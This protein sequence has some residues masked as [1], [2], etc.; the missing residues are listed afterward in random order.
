[1]LLLGFLAFT[2]GLESIWLKQSDYRSIWLK[3][4]KGN[5]LL[6][7]KSVQVA[8]YEGLPCTFKIA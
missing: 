1:M 5:F 7:M 3:N 4:N 2:E 6:E 8:L